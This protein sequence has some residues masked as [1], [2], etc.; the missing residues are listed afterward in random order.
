MSDDQNNP[1][2]MHELKTPEP[3]ES[4]VRS[5]PWLERTGSQCDEDEKLI[6]QCIQTI[7]QENKASVSLL[8]RRH[9]L[10]YSRAAR[11]MDELERRNV[12]GPA[13]AISGTVERKI[14]IQVRSNDS[15]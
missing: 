11:I 13:T 3:T 14:M 12:V 1:N 6:R 10:G 7:V 2:A 5:M 9:R 4:V 15:N 8:Q